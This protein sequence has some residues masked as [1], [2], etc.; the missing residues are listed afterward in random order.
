M[1]SFLSKSL[2]LNRL[3]LFLALT[4]T[5]ITF[6][7]SFYSNYEVQKEQLILQSIEGNQAYASKLAGTT[8]VFLGSVQQQLAYS[9]SFLADKMFDH[10]AMQ[11][12]ANRLKYQTDSFN[13]VVVT[14]AEGVTLAAS[15]ETL[16]IVGR[17]LRS[18]AREDANK[19]RA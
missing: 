14:N 10:Q 6:V 17:K 11:D 19:S 5:T 18:Q 16:N 1:N 9:T 7:N 8:E 13:S 15:P 4:A 3:I 2:K 12:E